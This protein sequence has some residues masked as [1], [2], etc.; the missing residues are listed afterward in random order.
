MGRE[1]FAA[2]LTLALTLFAAALNRFP[3][4]ALLHDMRQFVTEQV[5]ARGCIGIVMSRLKIDVLAL[6]VSKC[7]YR[8][9]ILPLM[10]SDIA[11][12]RTET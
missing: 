10:N 2:A 6:G 1:L 9:R 4:A 11:E 12:I 8:S 5:G 3:A 7:A